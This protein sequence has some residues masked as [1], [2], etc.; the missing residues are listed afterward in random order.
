MTTATE[1]KATAEP[2]LKKIELLGEDFL[3]V[4][5]HK[6]KTSYV[7]VFWLDKTRGF[8]VF[9]VK[10]GRELGCRKVQVGEKGRKGEGRVVT[11]ELFDKS[12]LLGTYTVN[13]TPRKLPRDGA[14]QSFVLHGK[15]WLI[16][17]HDGETWRYYLC[18][19]FTKKGTEQTRYRLV[20]ISDSGERLGLFD[21]VDKAVDYLEGEDEDDKDDE[22]L[23]PLG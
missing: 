8:D 4:R 1:T 18:E 11:Y 9:D 17:S 19:A 7:G 15:D 16:C 12:T 6:G 23:F 3:L 20:S 2:T 21:S 22:P 5:E 13:T 10:T 14:T